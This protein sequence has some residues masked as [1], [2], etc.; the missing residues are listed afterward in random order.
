MRSPGDDNVAPVI[1]L[2]QRHNQPSEASPSRRPLPRERAAF[3]PE[4]EPAEVVLQR[5]RP[6]GAAWG[7]VRPAVARPRVRLQPAAI[8]A[9]VA[10]M[11]AVG[12]L[13]VVILASQTFSS[14]GA[15]R[16]AIAP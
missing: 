7:R 13:V 16:S 1:P 8:V 15:R 14:A 9:V 2:R 6:L 4:L 5:R 3:D 12:V 10:A 11:V